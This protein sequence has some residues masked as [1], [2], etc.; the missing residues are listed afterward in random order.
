MASASTSATG[1]SP[2]KDTSWSH[3]LPFGLVHSTPHTGQ[4]AVQLMCT[5]CRA[6]PNGPALI[7]LPAQNTETVGVPTACA[8]WRAYKIAWIGGC[9]LYDRAA[10]VEAG[11]FDFWQ[12]L[13]AD[14][15]GEDVAA[16]Q[17]VLAR[18]GGA[19]VL[20]SGA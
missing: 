7:T 8:K 14:H 16:Q 13:P 19:G 20:P 1:T 4:A 2:T 5:R 6:R 15:A 11:G 10:L 17:R 9:V 12:R 3:R 18:F